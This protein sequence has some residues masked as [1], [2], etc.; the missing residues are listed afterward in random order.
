LSAFYTTQESRRD[1]GVTRNKNFAIEVVVP[2]SLAIES[3]EKS[4]LWAKPADTAAVA[5]GSWMDEL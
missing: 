5:A 4:G 1:A 2:V 3:C